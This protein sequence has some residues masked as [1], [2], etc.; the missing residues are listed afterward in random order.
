MNPEVAAYLLYNV[1]SIK[2]TKKIIDLVDKKW[3]LTAGRESRR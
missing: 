3:L 2:Y 1:I